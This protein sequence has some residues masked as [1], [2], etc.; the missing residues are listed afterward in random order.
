M[1]M[2]NTWQVSV[3]EVNPAGVEDLNALVS[4]LS[5]QTVGS[6]HGFIHPAP[7][8]DVTSASLGLN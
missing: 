5:F 8:C 6:E 2:I 7:R 4:D 1:K 3:E